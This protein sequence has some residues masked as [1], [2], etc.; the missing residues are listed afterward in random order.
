MLR[1]IAVTCNSALTA[2]IDDIKSAESVYFQRIC[3][4]IK[5]LT[6]AKQGLFGETCR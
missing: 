3:L 6:K 5:F 4:Y 1:F 2:G